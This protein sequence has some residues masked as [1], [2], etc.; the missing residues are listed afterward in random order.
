M[1]GIHKTEAK[2][3]K[4]EGE[5]NAEDDENAMAEHKMKRNAEDKSTKGGNI[6][7]DLTPW[8]RSERRL[9]NSFRNME[10]DFFRDM[11]MDSIEGRT[12]IQD[13]GDHYLLE[14]DLPGFDKEDIQIDA[15][16]GYLTIAAE[17][18]ETRDEKDKKGNYIRRERAY[19]SYSRSFDIS[20]IQEDGIKAEYKR[21][22]LKLILP[23]AEQKTLPGRRISIE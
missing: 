4:K 21:G 7:L 17:H 16:D 5:G 22:V 15:H 9:M 6:M 20:G 8:G 3:K 1:P 11:D 19:G 12:D 10:R 2:G 13:K 23:K 14:T 18:K